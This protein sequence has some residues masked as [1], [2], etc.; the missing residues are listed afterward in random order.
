MKIR[1]R[2]ILFGYPLVDIL[3]LW[4]IASIPAW[5]IPIFLIIAGFPIGAALIRHAAA[6]ASLIAATVYTTKPQQAPSA[7]HMSR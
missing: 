2:L 1:G 4:R 5:A 3:L 6:K 7:A